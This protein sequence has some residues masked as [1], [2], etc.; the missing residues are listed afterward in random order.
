[1]YIWVKIQMLFKYEWDSKLNL[2]SFL[3]IA[4]QS[5]V[6]NIDNTEK[7]NTVSDLMPN[8][9]TYGFIDF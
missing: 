8:H 5:S 4:S 2:N 6:E 1:M 3:T 7:W 9:L